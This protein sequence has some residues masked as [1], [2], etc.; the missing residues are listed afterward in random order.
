MMNKTDKKWITTDGYV[1]VWVDGKFVYEHILVMEKKLGRKLKRNEI[2][3][4]I[5]E[6]FEA[7]S[8]ND[9]SNLQV[10]TRSWHGK[11]HK[12]RQPYGIYWNK[13][14]SKWIL[15]IWKGDI[16]SSF[17]LYNTK[18]DALKAFESG[19]KIDRRGM[20]NVGKT[21]CKNRHEFSVKNTYIFNN[22]RRCRICRDAYNKIYRDGRKEDNMK[23]G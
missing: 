20:N 23:G 4:H 17:G 22:V 14:Y 1:T 9:E 6:S 19:I 21:H 8:N 15:F 2:I 3:H 5:D 10:V 7:R 12:T 18:E 11:H 13:R 16:F